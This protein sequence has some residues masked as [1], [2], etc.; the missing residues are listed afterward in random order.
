M[1]VTVAR[2]RDDPRLLARCVDPPLRLVPCGPCTHRPGQETPS[3]LQ[4]TISNHRNCGCVG[5]TNGP[6]F[7]YTGPLGNGVNLCNWEGAQG[8]VCIWRSACLGIGWLR[9]F[10]EENCADL[11][12]ESR[13]EIHVVVRLGQNVVEVFV[14]GE[15]YLNVFEGRVSV[16]TP[17]NCLEWP[18]PGNKVMDKYP[19][20]SGEP[21]VWT[22]GGAATIEAI[23]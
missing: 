23:P 2:C 17:Y 16:S 20:C 4:V 6:S 1:S 14:E 18:P 8:G 10:R 3:A 12:E 21:W 19:K 5:Y 7:R 11:Y 13:H 22:A 15:P 9:K